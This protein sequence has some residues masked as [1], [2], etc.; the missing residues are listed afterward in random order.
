M[1]K[2]A[3]FAL[4]L[5]LLFALNC[6]AQQDCQRHRETEGGFSICKPDG[7][8]VEESRGDKFKVLFAPRADAFTSNINFKEGTSA[9]PLTDYVA[10]EIKILMSSIE[11]IGATSIKVVSQSDFTTSSNLHG[12]KVVFSTEYKGFQFRQ[13]QYIFDIGG[14]RK[15]VVTGTGLEK[16]QQQLDPVFDRAAKSFQLDR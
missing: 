9:A 13:L 14:S 16:D 7:W 12:I 10:A 5:L 8:T 2:K 3:L 11:Q 6:L 15:L 1:M 4:T